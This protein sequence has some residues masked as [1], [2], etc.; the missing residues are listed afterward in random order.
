MRDL[1]DRLVAE[2]GASGLC[3]KVTSEP[4][5]DDVQGVARVFLTVKATGHTALVHFVVCDDL[6]C[7]MGANFDG[8]PIAAFDPHK[9]VE[10]LRAY[11]VLRK[12]CRKDEP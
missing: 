12:L 4:D 2:L 3:D 11:L 9:T 5:R 7:L 10:A 6:V 1:G 8:R